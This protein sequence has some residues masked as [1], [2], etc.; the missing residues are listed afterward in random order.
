MSAFTSRSDA[1]AASC[2]GVRTGSSAGSATGSTPRRIPG[3]VQPRVLRAAA[4]SQEVGPGCR[5]R[6][7][8]RSA[9]PDSPAC[10]CPSA[11][12]AEQTRGSQPSLRGLSLRR[13][14]G[15]RHCS[16]GSAG[17]ASWPGRPGV[18]S[19]CL[20]R[21]SY[22]CRRPPASWSRA[23]FSSS[24]NMR[25]VVVVVVLDDLERPAA[26]QHVAAQQILLEPVA[27]HRGARPHAAR[28]WPRRDRCRPNPSAGGIRT[29]GPEPARRSPAPP[30]ACR[31]PR[32]SRR[33]PRPE[34]DDRGPAGR[35]SLISATL[36]T[37][38]GG[39]GWR[40]A[41][42]PPRRRAG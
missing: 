14:L 2:S 3:R 34:S 21:A 22:R 25:P 8:R 23:D 7:R 15:C 38:S 33:S 18:R 13:H 37:G 39:D 28:R 10:A 1:A 5:S 16:T 20:S 41:D 17:A 27:R 6:H 29:G 32:P 4:R 42:E 26:V 12:G 31:G 19:C 35:C 24:R 40:G 11:P 36:R 9:G 30:T